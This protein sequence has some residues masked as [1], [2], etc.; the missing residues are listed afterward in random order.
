MEAHSYIPRPPTHSSPNASHSGIVTSPN[1][2]VAS[3][4]R[5]AVAGS[6]P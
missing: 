2:E 3:T 1:S 5:T 6:P 4:T